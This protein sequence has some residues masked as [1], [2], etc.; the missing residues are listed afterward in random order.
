MKEQQFET[1]AK[2]Y[3]QI[4]RQMKDYRKEASILAGVIRR[5]EDKPSKTLL[6]VGCGTG[7]HL[8]HLSQ[9]FQCK[10]IDISKNMIDIARKKVLNASFEI[11]DMTNFRLKEKFDVITCLFSAIGY[12]QSLRN[13]ERTFNN[14][15]S[16]SSGGGLVIVEPWVFRKDV[17][18]GHVSID[19]YEDEQ[20]KFTRLATS[21][22]TASQWLVYFHY[23]IGLDGK[24]TYM[25]ET[26]KMLVADREDYVRAL[27]LAGY[28][29]VKFIERDL[30]TKSRGLFIAKK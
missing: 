2:Y 22:V 30:W 7:E 18:K 28:K 1:F 26:H 6:D 19:T 5:F 10:G 17:R 24:I 14:F 27:E 8:K 23:L 20:V 16:H 3:D 25:K 15:N 12:V 11:A 9:S 4:Y 13:L 29:N 21:R